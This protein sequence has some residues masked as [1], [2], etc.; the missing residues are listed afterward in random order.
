MLPRLDGMTGHALAEQ[1][2]AACG[3]TRRHRSR[4]DSCEQRYAGEQRYPFH[5][6]PF[7]A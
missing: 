3:V 6:V 4:R 7:I 5:G 2:C 1:L